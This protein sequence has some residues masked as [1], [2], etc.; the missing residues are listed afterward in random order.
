MSCRSRPAV[1]L[2]ALLLL[3]L[4]PGSWAPAIAADPP[5]AGIHTA[6]AG[7]APYAGEDGTDSEPEPDAGESQP[8][9]G[10]APGEGG[11]LTC[12]ASKT[13]LELLV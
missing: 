5:I 4:A 9:T 10:E 1:N 8:G 3:A 7:E 6:Q 12:P 13:P 11:S 2:L